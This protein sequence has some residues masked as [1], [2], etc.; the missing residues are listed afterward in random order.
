MADRFVYSCRECGNAKVSGHKPPEAD[1]CFDCA[2][3]KSGL[4][5]LWNREGQI[6]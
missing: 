5:D 3:T 2:A 1:M 4:A 6:S